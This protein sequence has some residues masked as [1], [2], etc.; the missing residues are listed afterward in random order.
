MKI[1][2]KEGFGFR[3]GEENLMW[4]KRKLIRVKSE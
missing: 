3:Q 1:A 2:S 4:L